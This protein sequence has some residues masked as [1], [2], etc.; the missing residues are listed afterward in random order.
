VHSDNPQ[1][2]S[3]VKT[4]VVR[5]FITS[6]RAALLAVIAPLVLAGCQLPT[7]GAYHGITKGG[8]QTF[9]LWQ[10]FSV[11]AV[12][13]G[14]GTFLLILWVVFR[15]RHRSDA[16]PR[17]TQYN[18]PLEVLYTIV[19]ILV[20]I[21]LFAATVVVENQVLSEPTPK[22]TVNVTAFQWGWKFV[23]PGQNV[24]VV[25][26]TT[27]DPTMVVP[28]GENV[29]MNLRS[30]DVVHGFY[31]PELNFSR[32]A[33]P[34][35]LNTFTFNFDKLGVFKGQCTQ[36]CGLYHSLMYFKIQVVTKTQYQAWLKANALSPAQ[37]V[38]AAN[39]SANQINAGIPVKPAQTSYGVN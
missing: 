25:G 39:A 13:I 26:Q 30:S 28:L 37:A 11:I 18:V 38:A 17:Q 31:V 24:V 34:G 10:G 27:Q 20:V 7:F 36:L 22:A 15:Y 12:I 14:G 35:L 32:F 29:K 33:Q 9:K 2:G 4:G 21:G 8:S 5:K 1:S 23:Y 16:I 19:P 6:R 3:H